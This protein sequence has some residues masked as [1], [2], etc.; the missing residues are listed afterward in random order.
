[1]A[2][3]R[4][5]SGPGARDRARGKTATHSSQGPFPSVRAQPEQYARIDTTIGQGSAGHDSAEMNEKEGGVQNH[6]GLRSAVTV[7]LR[8]PTESPS[9]W[10]W[11]SDAILLIELRTDFTMDSLRSDP[12]YAELVRKIGF[13]QL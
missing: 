11:S 5:Q 2:G 6:G 12:R 10:F 8:S 9:P 1:M 13:P 7:Q 4:S 3:L